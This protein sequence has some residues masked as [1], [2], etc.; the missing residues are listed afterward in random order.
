MKRLSNAEKKEYLTNTLRYI[1][2]NDELYI[3]SSN[4]GKDVIF[5]ISNKDLSGVN[6]QTK[7]MTYEEMRC[8][9]DGV[10]AVKENRIKF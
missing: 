8:F 2:K 1:T 5:A 9:F 4:L 7:F 6:P 10:L 3:F